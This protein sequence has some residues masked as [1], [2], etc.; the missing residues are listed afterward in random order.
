MPATG[1]TPV[2][3]YQVH[4]QNHHIRNDLIARR[5]RQLACLYDPVQLLP[6]FFAERFT[7]IFGAHYAAVPVNDIG[8]AAQEFSQ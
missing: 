1:H 6:L 3:R 8:E 4:R 2:V 7:Q 5:V